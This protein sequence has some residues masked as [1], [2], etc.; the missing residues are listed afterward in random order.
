MTRLFVYG[1]LMF[2]EPNHYLL[3]GSPLLCGAHTVR[4]YVLLNLGAFPAML[5]DRAWQG[6][7]V[8]EVYRVSRET[9]AVLDRLEGHPTWYQRE[10]V[11]LADR[12]AA[13]AYLLPAPPPGSSVIPFGD[14]RTR[15]RPKPQRSTT[16][17]SHP[18]RS[19]P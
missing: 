17:R 12:S 16:R 5:H 7:V 11:A 4:G 8:G 14:W 13:Q 9:L 3:G 10:R 15:P 6:S 2:G 1:T 18:G 19:T